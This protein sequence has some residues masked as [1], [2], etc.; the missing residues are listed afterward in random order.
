MH[1]YLEMLLSRIFKG[2]IL[3][4]TKIIKRFKKA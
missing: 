2:L 4:K 3:M 1:I